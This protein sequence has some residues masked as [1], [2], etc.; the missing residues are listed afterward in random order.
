[1]EECGRYPFEVYRH[2]KRK[3]ILAR[4][5]HAMN[6]VSALGLGKKSDPSRR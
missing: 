2:R 1:M 6:N 4:P 5:Y 3:Q